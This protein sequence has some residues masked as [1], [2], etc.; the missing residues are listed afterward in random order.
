MASKNLPHLSG[1]AL[2]R[3]GLKHK[4][5]LYKKGGADRS[6]K[7][8]NQKIAPKRSRKKRTKKGSRQKGFRNMERVMG[9]EPT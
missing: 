5:S 4:K 6:R 8:G 7:K 2:K 9:I 1:V 3:G